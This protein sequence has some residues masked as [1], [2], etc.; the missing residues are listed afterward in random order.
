[1]LKF[2]FFLLNLLVYLLLSA[3]RGST[4]IK[5][6]AKNLKGLSGLITLDEYDNDTLV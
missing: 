3:C 1:M 6:P 5:E 4:P 2:N